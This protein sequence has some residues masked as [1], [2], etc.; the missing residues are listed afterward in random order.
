MSAVR[1]LSLTTHFLRPDIVV[2]VCLLL[3]LWGKVG[4]WERSLSRT[5]GFSTTPLALSSPLKTKHPHF[6]LLGQVFS[7][8]ICCSKS[9]CKFNEFIISPSYFLAS[10]L[11]G[12]KSLFLLIPY[13]L[14]VIKSFQIVLWNSYSLHPDCYHPHPTPHHL[15]PGLQG[16]PRSWPLL[17]PPNL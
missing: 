16:Q 14:S 1:L 17:I 9:T 11:P 5:L 3:T 8:I 4:R 15:T 12:T 13:I 2:S 7:S 10:H 6:P